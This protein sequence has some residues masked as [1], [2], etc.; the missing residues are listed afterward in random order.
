MGA[1]QRFVGSNL[2]FGEYIFNDLQPAYGWLCIRTREF[3]LRSSVAFG[4]VWKQE[5]SVD[6]SATAYSGACKCRE[7]FRKSRAQQAWLARG[8]PRARA[9]SKEFI[10]LNRF[11]ARYGDS[12]RLLRT[13]ALIEKAGTDLGRPCFRLLRAPHGRRRLWSRRRCFGCVDFLWDGGAFFEIERTSPRTAG[14]DSSW[15]DSESVHWACSW[16]VDPRNAAPQ[17]RRK[18]FDADHASRPTDRACDKGGAGQRFISDSVVLDALIGLR[19]RLTCAEQVPAKREFGGAVPVSQKSVAPN[20]NK[21]PGQDVQQ[22]TP[23]EF[24]GSDGHNLLTAAVPVI[25]PPE[26]NRAIFH[27]EEAVVWDRYAMRVSAE[28]IQYLLWAAE[29]PFRVNDPFG[30]SRW[31]EQLGECSPLRQR[32]EL[33]EKVQLAITERL[34]ERRQE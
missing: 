29:R 11:A 4:P 5:N 10:E 16:A 34:P 31:G 26:A 14:E 18:G 2:T 17:R 23:D 6:I 28:I 8:Q 9:L 32:F 7:F 15:T 13:G 19:L 20:A 30:A 22:E 3:W 33:R 21:A 24:L 12:I 27:W 25:L 1:N